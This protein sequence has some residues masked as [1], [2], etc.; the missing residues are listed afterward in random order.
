MLDRLT[1]P[2][3]G[4]A[5]RLPADVASATVLCPRCQQPLPNPEVLEG[6]TVAVRARTPVWAIDDEAPPELRQRRR[7]FGAWMA[8]FFGAVL[9][10]GG[11]TPMLP[12]RPQGFFDNLTP[13]SAFI[14]V[15]GVFAICQGSLVGSWLFRNFFPPDRDDGGCFD[16]IL[17]IFLWLALT[18]VSMA[19]AILLF[20]LAY[21]GAESIVR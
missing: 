14:A 13:I 18:G 17:A 21:R 4:S 10:A 1:C 5:L 8:A 19:V 9:L 2:H 11:V 20:V 16:L 12:A 3:C 15:I 7:R 6:I